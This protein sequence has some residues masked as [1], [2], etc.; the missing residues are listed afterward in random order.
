MKLNS[1]VILAASIAAS[2][3]ASA[4]YDA[5]MTGQLEGFYVYADGDYVYFRLKNQPTSH[6]GCNP[7]YFVIPSTVP[8]D[9]RKAM[10]ARLSLAYAMQ[11]TVNI[12]YSANGDCGHGYI[13]VYRVG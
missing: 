9:R 2:T 4:S 7:A 10:L 13:N 3:L 8:A 5:N 1:L 6:N 12:G 11:E